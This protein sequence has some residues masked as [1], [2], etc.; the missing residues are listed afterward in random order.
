[1]I[2]FRLSF[3]RNRPIHWREFQSHFQRNLVFKKFGFRGRNFI[4]SIGSTLQVRPFKFQGSNG[5]FFIPGGSKTE[6]VCLFA[7]LDKVL[8][9][10]ESLRSQKLIRGTERII[11]QRRESRSFSFG[12]IFTFTSYK[13]VSLETERFQQICFVCFALIILSKTWTFVSIP[14]PEARALEPYISR[15]RF[16]SKRDT[17]QTSFHVEFQPRHYTLRAHPRA[18]EQ[19]FPKKILF[20]VL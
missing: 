18:S 9:N 16:W 12:H 7:V 17:R 15:I 3:P 19:S 6:I 20:W 8:T 1:M 5:L 4:T 14:I 10:A 2:L 11:I 13:A